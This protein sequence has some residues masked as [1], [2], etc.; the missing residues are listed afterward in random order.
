LQTCR[1]S[2]AASHSLDTTYPSL[3]PFEREDSPSSARITALSIEFVAKPNEAHRVHL[4]LPSAIAGALGNVTGFAG[5]YVLISSYEARLVTV[6]TLWKGI[7]RAKHCALNIRWVRAL[8]G[9][10][11]DRCLR[12]QTMT[13]YMAATEAPQLDPEQE[14]VESTFQ[15]LTP[16][17]SPV[18]VA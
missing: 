7:D 5:S 2:K 8:L 10:Y 16:D 6:V 1:T 15:S 18:C 13:A 17:E 12:V 9:P 14:I 11:L 4:A 3:N